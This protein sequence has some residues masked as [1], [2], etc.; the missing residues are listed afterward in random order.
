MSFQNSIVLFGTQNK[1]R[2]STPACSLP[3]YNFLHHD[4]VRSVSDAVHFSHPR[5][6]VIGLYLLR[7]A[8]GVCVLF[9]QP[10]KEFLRLLLDVCKVPVQRP[11]GQQ[12]IIQHPVVRLQKSSPPL[13]VNADGAFFFGR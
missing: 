9:Y 12:V 1:W 8:L 13:A 10:K 2:L 4:L 7:H 3:I 11:G 5:L 6:R